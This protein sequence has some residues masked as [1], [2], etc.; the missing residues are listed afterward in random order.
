MM[1]K[2]RER[3]RNTPRQ[4]VAVR[5]FDDTLSLAAAKLAF[6]NMERDQSRRPS[7]A[8]TVRGYSMVSQE[9]R[10][11][12]RAGERTVSLDLTALEGEP[13]AGVGRFADDSLSAYSE[14]ASAA[15]VTASMGEIS[16]DMTAQT[17][18]TAG[19]LRAPRRVASALSQTTTR[20]ARPR[21]SLDRAPSVLRD[22]TLTAPPSPRVGQSFLRGGTEF[23]TMSRTLRE[24]NQ[25]RSFAKTFNL[26]GFAGATSAAFIP[27]PLA[28][29][30]Q[31]IKARLAR[32]KLPRALL[33][34]VRKMF[35]LGNSNDAET[36]YVSA[37]RPQR[38]MS[39]AYGQYA[40]ADESLAAAA[41][42]NISM[43]SVSTITD[44][45]AGGHD[46]TAQTDAPSFDGYRRPYSRAS[47]LRGSGL[48]ELSATAGSAAEPET[49]AHSGPSS[50]GS[51][52]LGLDSS[53][54]VS[55]GTAAEERPRTRADARARRAASGASA[56]SAASGG[57]AVS[58]RLQPSAAQQKLDQQRNRKSLYEETMPDALLAHLRK[59]RAAIGDSTDTSSQSILSAYAKPE[60]DNPWA[61]SRRTHEPAAS[62][63]A[64]T[65]S[66]DDSLP[67]ADRRAAYGAE[68][69]RFS[70]PV[71]RNVAPERVYSALMRR[72]QNSRPADELEQAQA[73][74]LADAAALACPAGSPA[75][76]PAGV[77][78]P[79]TPPQLHRALSDEFLEPR[80]NS[81]GHADTSAADLS[82]DVDEF[83]PPPPESE[84]EPEPQTESDPEPATEADDDSGSETSRASSPARDD[85]AH[86]AG[87]VQPVPRSYAAYT[88]PAFGRDVDDLDPAEF[89]R[90][91]DFAS[92][93]KPVGLAPPRPFTAST[94]SSPEPYPAL[95]DIQSFADIPVIYDDDSPA[96][97]RPVEYT[98]E[99]DMTEI[100]FKDTHIEA[101]SFAFN[102]PALAQA[103]SPARRS[104]PPSRPLSN[105]GSPAPRRR[106]SSFE[107]ETLAAL[108]FRADSSPDPAARRK[109]KLQD[110]PEYSSFFP[111]TGPGRREQ[112]PAAR[113][114]W[115]HWKDGSEL[116]KDR[117]DREADVAKYKK[118][119]FGNINTNS[120]SYSQFSS[121]LLSSGYQGYSPG[122][123]SSQYMAGHNDENGGRSY[124]YADDDR[125]MPTLD[126]SGNISRYLDDLR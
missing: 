70:K 3:G 60:H 46:L 1:L 107:T 45:G 101:L 59:R 13:F 25:T 97:P 32:K 76:R 29:Q 83:Q 113:R 120:S 73:A 109:A 116:D 14:D 50:S 51:S 48:D 8:S 11:Y 96:P 85:V 27:A 74:L 26:G 114:R 36:S 16:A 110:A 122:S 55:H 91:I 94:A 5:P 82:T 23:Q 68:L 81:F 89:T 28:D 98:G 84:S 62:P 52:R 65:T 79:V 126:V 80:G 99:F 42:R 119:A 31:Q 7:M 106:R 21:D 22:A 121:P 63:L 44:A 17:A 15:M 43:A 112:S 20:T 49:Q 95:H 24:S 57:S 111:Y 118:K 61:E 108:S 18:R 67:R 9:N 125:R 90:K 2:L 19:T 123:S 69:A 78:R 38:S 47:T 40:A 53:G 72:I 93:P 35:F 87:L 92:T 115:H 56:V 58:G 64:H 66:P 117:A 39:V 100:S 34:G 124:H 86:F 10:T 33:R 103:P 41:R 37:Y 88:M 102:S 77:L 75:A 6:Q 30:T 4:E 105:A 54:D 71:S 104:R 12:S